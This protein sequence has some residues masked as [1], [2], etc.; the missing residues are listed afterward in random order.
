MTVSVIIPT[1][2][3]VHTL[4]RALDSVYAQ[5]RSATEVIVIDDGSTDGTAQLCRRYPGLNYIQQHQAGVSAARNHGIRVASGQWLAFLDSDDAWEPAKLAAQMAAIA[6]HPEF[7]I[8]HCDEQWIRNGR[9][10]NPG[11]RHR[12]CQGDLFN[13]S[14][15]L[16][17]ISP[18]AVLIQRPV[19]EHF[20]VFDEDLPACEDYDLWLRLCCRL[21]VLLVDQPLVVKYGGHA[22]QLSRHYPGMDRFRIYALHKLL[23]SGALSMQQAGAA[24][25]MLEKKLCIYLTGVEKRQ[26]REEAAACHALLRYHQ[27]LGAVVSPDFLLAG[28]L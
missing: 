20:G 19:V 13:Q 5:T 21:P 4:A 8:C 12:K 9:R 24:R 2:N 1:C 26:R 10:V 18:S 14:L 28:Q 22:D 11:Q 16:C 6:Q 17:A 25:A 7:K 3:R 27:Q 15:E 23:L